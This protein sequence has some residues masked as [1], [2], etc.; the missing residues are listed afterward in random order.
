MRMLWRIHL[1]VCIAG[2][3][4]MF[5]SSADAQAPVPPNRAS[6]GGAEEQHT[7]DPAL[8]PARALLL[9]GKLTEAEAAARNFL[10]E[11]QGSADAHFLLGFILFRE[12]SAKWRESGQ[13]Q[14]E[15]LLYSRSDAGGTIAKY[16]DDKAR[17]SLAE[18]TAGAQFHAPNAFDLKIVALDYILLKD[19]IDADRWLTSS[20][21]RNPRDAQAWYYLGRTKYSEGRFPEAIQAYVQCLKLEPHN[22]PAETNVGL[23]YEALNQPD[24]ARQAFENA[25]AWEAE[26]PAKDP[27]PFIELAHLYLNQNQADKALPPLLRAISLFHNVAKS[28]EELARAYSL[29]NR[30]PD[31]QQELEKAVT[32]D[33]ESGPLHCQLGQIYRQ[34]KMTAKAAGEFDRCTAL[35]PADSAKTK[36]SN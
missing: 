23:S 11:H 22:I 3:L 30:L 1:S 20:L 34:Q 32:L 7:P 33:P 26:I 9:D 16:R 2:L 14:S 12:I 35:Q 4:C 8:S 17:E 36:E 10:D 28:H 5:G 13:T 21:Q 25:I 29:L 24:Q 31:A 15:N 27:E 6:Q 18:F 19:Y